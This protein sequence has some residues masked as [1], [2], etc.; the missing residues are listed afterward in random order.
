M[1]MLLLV[2]LP[3]F[4]VE[5]T[6]GQYARCGAVPTLDILAFVDQ[7]V[8]SWPHGTWHH[9][10]ITLV[11]NI[12]ICGQHLEALTQL[13]LAPPEHHLGTMWT[14]IGLLLALFDISI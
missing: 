8:S 1:V 11:Y 2:G 12:H 6:A 14:T 5:L 10:N 9:L 7:N 13:I 4:F 3:A